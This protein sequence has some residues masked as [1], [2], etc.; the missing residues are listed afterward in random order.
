MSVQSQG[1]VDAITTGISAQ[2]NGPY[3]PLRV[4]MAGASYEMINGSVQDRP[5]TS[6]YLQAIMAPQGH[7]FRM[8]GNPG[9]SCTELYDQIVAHEANILNAEVPS[10]RVDAGILGLSGEQIGDSQGEPYNTLATISLALDAFANYSRKVYAIKPP[11]TEGVDW[12]Y[13][14]NPGWFTDAKWDAYI[15]SW[16]AHLEANHP[17]VGIIDAYDVWTDSK[18]Y[19]PGYSPWGDWHLSTASAARGARN[20]WARISGELSPIDYTPDGFL[21]P[22]TCPEIPR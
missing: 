20:I 7:V 21:P 18:E 8:L 3:A 16:V 4:V 6:E 11:R 10:F 1:I 17:D 9:A 2:T 14:R 22:D 5:H 13:I 12:C 15:A 19:A